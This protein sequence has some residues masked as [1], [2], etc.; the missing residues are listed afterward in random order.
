MFLPKT[1][2]PQAY[3]RATH[4]LGNEVV[5]LLNELG[6]NGNVRKKSKVEWWFNGDPVGWLLEMS[7]MCE[8]GKLMRGLWYCRFSWKKQMIWWK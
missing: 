5:D 1:L 3:N 7:V 2:E 4:D 6:R 8:H